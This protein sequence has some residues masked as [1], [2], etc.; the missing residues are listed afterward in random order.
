[1]RIALLLSIT[2][3][4]SACASTQPSTT[5]MPAPQTTLVQGGTV[6][7]VRDMTM[8]GG[9]SSG[10]GS[11][12]GAVLG[13]IAGSMIG[14]GNGSAVASVGGAVAGGIAGEHLAQVGSVRRSIE[15]T[16]KL[17]SGEQ[18]TYSMETGENF[19]IG[20]KVRVTTADGISRLS[21]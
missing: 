12:I 20:D 18:R 17:N 8:Q 2:L 16:V 6:T 13:G 10:L 14:N 19:R 21:H 1:M 4:L 9:H 5:A 15:V 3:V 11:V 7:D